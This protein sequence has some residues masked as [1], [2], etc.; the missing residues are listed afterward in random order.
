MGV[1]VVRNPV[2]GPA[3]V[4]DADVAAEVL[5][6]EEML[7]IGDLALAFEYV[8]TPVRVT[9]AT[10]ALSYPLYSRR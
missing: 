4:G 5:S 8:E 10:P 7:Q 2:R 1:G 9:S 3:G 6:V